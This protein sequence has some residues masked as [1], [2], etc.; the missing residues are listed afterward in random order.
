M[1]YLLAFSLLLLALG[2]CS[3]DPEISLSNMGIRPAMSFESK[4]ESSGDLGSAF[5]SDKWSKSEIQLRNNENTFIYN[6]KVNLITGDL[7]MLIRGQEY[8]VELSKV[9][10]MK[11]ISTG[12]IFKY[13]D[14]LQRF[15]EV[16]YSN[17]GK[18]IFQ[19]YY[20]HLERAA[21]NPVLDAGQRNDSW[22][23]ESYFLIM[24]ND[25]LLK[26]K[27]KKALYKFLLEQ[28]LVVKKNQIPDKLDKEG[29]VS[30]I[31]SL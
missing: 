30:L 29:L 4:L 24:L 13:L 20:L 27:N 17:G 8:T 31:S 21:Y 5:L 1:K 10:S 18:S 15:V 26:V 22:K 12:R 25:N 11:E 2:V 3:Q 14:S 23:Q 16:I 28:D 19:H 9:E 6:T 7:H